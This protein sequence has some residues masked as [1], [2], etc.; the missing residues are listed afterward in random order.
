MNVRVMR[1]CYVVFVNPMSSSSLSSSRISLTPIAVTVVTV[2]HCTVAVVAQ[3]TSVLSS[4]C[5][6]I[7][8]TIRAHNIVDHGGT[9]AVIHAIH[10]IGPTLTTPLVSGTLIRPDGQTKYGLQHGLQHGHQHGL[11]H[12]PVQRL[13]AKE[14]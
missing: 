14:S 12:P 1:M 5:R 10:Q 6:E 4:Q 2:S 11:R 7:T 3:L 8:L 9:V 13:R